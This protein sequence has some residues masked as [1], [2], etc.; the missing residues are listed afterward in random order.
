[1][2]LAL[3]L[4]A[5][6]CLFLQLVPLSFFK[7]H[8]VW[9]PEL[10]KISGERKPGANSSTSSSCQLTPTTK[11]NRSDLGTAG[12]YLPLT[13]APP[14]P[15]YIDPHLAVKLEEQTAGSLVPGSLAPGSF[16]LVTLG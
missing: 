10:V 12:L 8:S 2:R 14:S 9:A 15:M 5:N 16:R 1:M 4:T 13:A 3:G 11:I 6:V 7:L